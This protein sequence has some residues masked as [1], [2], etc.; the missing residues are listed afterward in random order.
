[1]SVKGL[2]RL[3]YYISR[4]GKTFGPY[5][6]NSILI[7][8]QEGR[9][10]IHDSAWVPRNKNWIPLEQILEKNT[11]GKIEKSWLSKALEKIDSQD[12]TS[13]KLEIIEWACNQCGLK[14]LE[15]VARRMYVKDDSG[16]RHL[17]PHPLEYT[18][19]EKYLGSNKTEQGF[20]EL[21]YIFGQDPK[22]NEEAAKKKLLEYFDMLGFND[23][24]VMKARKKLSSL[25]FK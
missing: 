18:I 11:K 17:C 7:F 16:E 6:Q 5:S 22:W 13:T 12:T 14:P 3:I 10:D 1:M 23:P 25:M 4:N 24:N 21:L 20:N 19:A 9:A 15:V 8:I 2:S